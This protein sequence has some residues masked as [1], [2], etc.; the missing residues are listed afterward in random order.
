MHKAN[1]GDRVRVQYSR[2][3]KRGAAPAK[4]FI[5]KTCEFTV[6]SS[7]VFPSL[8]VG[9]V[10]MA[11]GDRKRLTLQPQEA[12]WRGEAE[13]HPANTTAAFSAAHRARRRVRD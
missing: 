8:S 9:V 6:G 12:V 4:A 5:P 10:G 1:L 3:S 7:D 13:A 11:P 2:V